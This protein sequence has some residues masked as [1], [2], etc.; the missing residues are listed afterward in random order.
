[1]TAKIIDG[2]VVSKQVMED[3]KP[4]IASLKEKEIIPGLTVVIVGEDPASMSYVKSKGR[5]CERLGIG[6]ETIM[7]KDSTSQ[8]DLLAVIDNLN[9]NPGVHG[10]LVQLPLPDQIDEDAV[11]NFIN[12]EKDV[13]GFSPINMGR[14]LAGQPCFR[15]C[16]PNGVMRLL[17]YYNIDPEGK[18]VVIVG[19][20]NI[21]GKPMAALLMQ[22]ARGANATVTICHSRTKDLANFTRQADILIAAIGKP[23]F[24]QPEMVKQGAVVIDVGIHRLDT[25]GSEKGYML[26]G[27]VKFHGVDEVA[28][29]I[30]PVPG[31]VGRM[32][33]AMLMENTVQAAENSIG[34][35]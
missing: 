19:R 13:D 6:S 15:P 2:K 23:N 24:I 27:D 26:I 35:V 29:A 3:L 1:M 33:I 7:L 12:P 22:K 4:R 10:I 21:V 32:T 17:E 5:A 20:S 18:H 34:G 8:E 30:T 28:S 11:I 14:L 25:I 9:K 16:T 31:G